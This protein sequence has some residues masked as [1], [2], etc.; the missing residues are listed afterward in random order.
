MLALYKVSVIVPV[1]NN[2]RYVAECIESILNQTHEN[3][4]LILINDGSTDTSLN[5][6]EKYKILDERIK[7][8]SIQNSGV[9]TARNLGLKVMTGDYVTFVDSDDWIESNTLETALT[10]SIENNS[11]ITIW[12]YFKNYKSKEVKLSLVPGENRD[13]VSDID[14]E[15]LY[16]KSIYSQ[17]E[18]Q[19]KSED[20]PIGTVMCKLYKTSFIRKYNLDFNPNLIRSEDII[21]ALNAFRLA[22]KIT[23]FD[24]NLYHYRINNSS[25]SFG[26]KYIQDT[27]TPFNLL[28]EELKKFQVKMNNDL[29]VIDMINCRIIQIITW[30]VR[31]NYFNKE[32]TNR[33]L[34]SRK[35][36]IKLINN[37]DYKD[38]LKNV[39][40]KNLSKQ[41]RLLVIFYRKKMILTYEIVRKLL[42]LRN[43]FKKQY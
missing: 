22:E 29:T 12:S 24:S 28:I 14:K 41:Q 5:I 38:A 3:L 34:R 7:L 31:Y 40:L 10:N 30:H 26:Y 23:Y 20:V 32:N 16:L 33:L 37:T 27:I 43:K 9:S 4:E 19:T 17:Y 36:L 13:F 6:C 2:E 21:F 18:K 25:M 39:K 1:Y 11:D 35:D 15:I 42:E 8:I